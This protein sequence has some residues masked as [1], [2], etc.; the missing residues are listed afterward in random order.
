MRRSGREDGFTLV[1]LLLVI[2]IIVLA[3]SMVFIY[4]G[5]KDRRSL[6]VRLE[7]EQLAQTLRQARGLAMDEKAVIGVAFNISNAPG[8]KGT[9][10]NNRAGGH[11]YRIMGPVRSNGSQDYTGGAGGGYYGYYRFERLNTFWWVVDPHNGDAAVNGVLGE[12]ANDWIGPKIVL[13]KNSVR[14]IALADQDNGSHA[15]PNWDFAPTYPR[16]WFGEWDPNNHRLYAWG[17]YDQEAR[18]TDFPQN[19]EW[20]GQIKHDRTNR[21]GALY[22]ITGFYYEGWDGAITGCV[23]PTDRLVYVDTNG[24]GYA[25]LNDTRT[26]PL[27]KAGDPRP[28]VNGDWLDALILF[29][30]DGHAQYENWM[31]LRHEYGKWSRENWM[32]DDSYHHNLQELAMGDMCNGINMAT[33]WWWSGEHDWSPPNDRYEVAHYVDRTGFWYITL[34]PDVD[35]DK[36][37]FDSPQQALATMMPMMRVGVSP[38]GEVKLVEVK[39]RMKP[40]V[41]L[42]GPRGDAWWQTCSHTGPE[43]YYNNLLWATTGTAMPVEDFVTPEMLANRQWWMRP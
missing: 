13:P 2:A 21:N 34:G 16:P 19:P 42:D 25:D 26:W 40:G 43:S 4:A 9:V 20:F 6:Q 22:N 28:L 12:W 3:M 30:P 7:A 39:R 36:D 8:S 29:Y 31:R 10:L 33:Y 37:T 1:E 35:T 41:T 11:W 38:L 32:F 24:N 14:F 23:Q 15:S 27:W 17:G 18:F 5:R